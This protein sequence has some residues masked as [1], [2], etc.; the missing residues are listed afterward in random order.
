MD[1]LT[2]WE[3]GR[4]AE[5]RAFERYGGIKHP[6]YAS[7]IPDLERIH[8][9]TI[10]WIEVKAIDLAADF[11]FINA[12]YHLK[13][14]IRKRERVIPKGGNQRAFLLFTN[15]DG[16]EEEEIIEAVRRNLK[17]INA[18]IDIEI[19]RGQAHEPPES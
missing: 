19:M 12:M 2:R 10:E 5:D 18:S 16:W 7:T 17:G 11:S 13:S 6:K 15:A 9:G 8:E 14:Q 4:F 1:D 3:K